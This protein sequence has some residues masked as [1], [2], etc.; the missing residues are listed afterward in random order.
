MQ[1][2]TEHLLCPFG[3]RRADKSGAP[4]Q[5]LP[6][7]FVAAVGKLVE[8]NST[9]RVFH[10]LRGLVGEGHGQNTAVGSGLLQGQGEVLKRQGVGF[11]PEPAD[12]R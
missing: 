4:L 5:L 12:E 9:M 2:L 11:F 1:Q 10:L 3:Q 6:Q 7:R 8:K